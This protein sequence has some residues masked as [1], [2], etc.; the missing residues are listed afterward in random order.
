MI[1]TAERVLSSRNFPKNF[2][3]FDMR[4]VPKV[5]GDNDSEK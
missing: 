1:E 2:M 4:P 3:K 5:D